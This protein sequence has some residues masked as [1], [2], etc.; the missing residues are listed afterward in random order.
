MRPTNQPWK[1]TFSWDRALL[2]LDQGSSSGT[3]VVW[4][5]MGGIRPLAPLPR[6]REFPQGADDA[7]ESE[8]SRGGSPWPSGSHV[9]PWLQAAVGQ[10]DGLL[11]Q[12]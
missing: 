6:S 12:S 1:S 11:E 5:L 4:A 9:G 8:S 10:T 7:G 2:G 3:W